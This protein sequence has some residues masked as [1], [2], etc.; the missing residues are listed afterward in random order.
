[1]TRE[2]V[3]LQF[4]KAALWK[5]RTDLSGR[6]WPMEQYQSLM[7]LAEQQAVSGLTAQ[8]LMDSGLRLPRAAAAEVYA[9]TGAT[10]QR[11]EEMD[12]AVVALCQKME[13]MGIRIIIFK[14]Q[15]LAKLYPDPGI[16]QSGD[17]DFACHP[18][19]WDRA[20]GYLI[21]N[22]GVTISDNNSEKHIEFV[23][24]GIQ[25]E[26]HHKLTSF[27]YSG[28]QRYWDEVIMPEVWATPYSIDINGYQVPTLPPLHNIL[29]IFIHIFFH[30]I[31]DGIGLRQFCDWAIALSRLGIR[32]EQ[33]EA[34]ET[35]LRGIGLL[36][37]YTGTGAI[38]TDYLGLPAEAFPLTITDEDHRRAPALLKNI[39]EMGNF[40]KN[41][42][43]TTKRGVL[44]GLQHLWRI[45]GQARRFY[46]YAPTEAL[47]RIPYMFRWWGIKIKRTITSIS[48]PNHRIFI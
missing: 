1:M 43:Y 3:L 30:L 17:I 44:H 14:G 47:W 42:H 18:D 35:H 23:I 38:L 6:Q 21:N 12:T 10:R 41:K 26:M 22:R 46:H 32:G 28:H 8:T 5:R 16:R 7:A 9:L 20:I 2:D 19:D 4:L 45:A 11:N 37:A 31:I 29:Y 25:Y 39:W 34:L 13:E 48:A 27:A 33:V 15:T 40:G 24:D 36:K